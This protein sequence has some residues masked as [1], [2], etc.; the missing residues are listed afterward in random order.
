MRLKR[1]RWSKGNKNNS[2]EQ[3]IITRQGQEE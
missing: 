3:N 2:N 1:K